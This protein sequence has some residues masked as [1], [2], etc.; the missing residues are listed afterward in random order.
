M[1]Q[2]TLIALLLITLVNPLLFARATEVKVVTEILEPYQILQPDGRLTGYA[3]EVV[4]QLLVETGIKSTIQVLPWARAYQLAL[5]Q[6]NILIYSMA[7]TP[8]R[9]TQF[10]WVGDLNEEKLYFWGLAKNKEKLT[11]LTLTHKTA[12]LRDSNI[13]EYLTQ[14]GFKNIHL[15][16]AEEQGIRM[17]F[18]QRVDLIID[19]EMT[20]NARLDKVKLNRSELVRLDE[21]PELNNQLSVALSHTTADEVVNQFKDAYSKLLNNGTLAKLKEK[22]GIL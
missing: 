22:W 9:L 14:A 16:T 6:P 7:Q 15:L 12:A 20:L 21:V 3:T 5:R 19:N 13:A 2:R 18:S 4:K 11:P 8:A 1:L 10:K 17:L